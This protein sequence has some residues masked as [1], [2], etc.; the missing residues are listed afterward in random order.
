MDSSVEVA[1][2]YVRSTL[3]RIGRRSVED[4]ELLVSEV[5]TNAVRHSGSGRRNGGV[6]TL[7][8]Y[9]DGETVRVEVTDEGS[10]ETMPQVRERP[11][12]LSEGGRGLWMVHELSSSWGWGQHD[13]G[14]TV[15]FEVRI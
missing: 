12:L 15:W 3:R 4:I 11:S 8:V 6:V 5:F 13:A 9:D 10:S 1:R 14:R 2:A 7:R